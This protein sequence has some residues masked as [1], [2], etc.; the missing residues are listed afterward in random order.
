MGL[1]EIRER[2]GLNKTQL[3]ELAGIPRVTISKYETGATNP[4]NMS[5]K[6]A[7]R[8]ADVLDCE[9]REFLK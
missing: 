1:T 9:P 7:Y 3:A 6:M 2:R 4:E 5:L 8:L